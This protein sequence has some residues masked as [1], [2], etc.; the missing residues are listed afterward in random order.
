[1]HKVENS[2]KSLQFFNKPAMFLIPAMTVIYWN[3]LQLGL[4]SSSDFL[5]YLGDIFRDIF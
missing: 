5:A 3:T 2:Q 4:I 1:M